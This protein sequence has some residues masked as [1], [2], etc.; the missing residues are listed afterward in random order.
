ML[1]IAPAA[2]GACHC[3]AAPIDTMLVSQPACAAE[4]RDGVLG[5]LADLDPDDARVL[6]DTLECWFAAHGST[7]E[8]GKQLHSHRNTVLHRTWSGGT[9]RFMGNPRAHAPA[10]SSQERLS[11]RRPPVVPDFSRSTPSSRWVAYL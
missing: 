1:C 11:G 10:G 3:G 7:A 2:V 5:G 4:L 8:C 6:L 9:G